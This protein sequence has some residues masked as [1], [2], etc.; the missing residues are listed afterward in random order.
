MATQCREK[1]ATTNRNRRMRGNGITSTNY[2]DEIIE[3][4][5]EYEEV[6]HAKSD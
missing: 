5:S 4:M 6:S 3:L 1:Q 2:S